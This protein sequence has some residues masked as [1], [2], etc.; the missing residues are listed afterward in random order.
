MDNT[1]WLCNLIVRAHERNVMKRLLHY[2]WLAF[3]GFFMYLTCLMI[4]Q[5]AAQNPFNRAPE[6]QVDISLY[7]D[8]SAVVAGESFQVAIVQDISAGWH[9]YFKNPGDSGAPTRVNW[10]L[11]SDFTAG[12]L[13][14]PVPERV[15]YQGL[16][17]FGYEDSVI[18]LT[19]ITPPDVL[20]QNSVTLTANLNWLAC[21]DICIPE[22]GTY[23]LTLPVH[24]VSYSDNDEIFSRARARQA[25]AVD[26]P[27][28]FSANDNTFTLTLT[29]GENIPAGNVTLF[30]YQDGL[31]K[32]AADQTVKRADESIT[33]T[34]PRGSADFSNIEQ[35]EFLVRV[36]TGTL[37]RAYRIKA[38]Y[39]NAPSPSQDAP[40][41]SS[42]TEERS[43]MLHILFAILGGVIL[44]LMPCV[45]PVLSLKALGL[46]QTRDKARAHVIAH[47]AAYLGGILISF[48]LFAG[49]ILGL[50]A[51]GT[52][53]GWGF[54]LQN[55]YN[56]LL[57]SYLIFAIGLNLSGVFTLSGKFMNLGSSLTQ[58]TT[59]S[60]SFFTGILAALVATPCTA[61][62]M[63]GAI[64][65]AMVEPVPQAF[66][67]FLAIGFGLA[68]PY[69][70]LTILPPVQKILPRPGQWMEHFRQ[71]LAFPMFLTA[72][73]LLWVLGHQSGI[74]AV[75]IALTGMVGFALFL[76]TLRFKHIVGRIITA[77]ILALILVTFVILPKENAPAAETDYTAYTPAT[78]QTALNS[79]DPVFINMTA[80]WC[81]TCKANENLALNTKSSRALFKQENVRILVGDWT[82]QNPDITEYL[83]RFGRNGVPLYV[84]YE[85]PGE[86]GIRPDPVVLPQ[87]LTNGIISRTIAP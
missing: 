11:P 19:T 81:I 52:S 26:W 21:N 77:I 68:L 69:V 1:A 25:K 45:F 75:F 76:W 8:T 58:K 78:L 85:A 43:L 53:L 63:A 28:E 72:A 62:F 46:I 35:A 20:P 41:A 59:Y 24:H 4:P 23:R 34:I 55:P 32:N 38:E 2:R 65:Y 87:I 3:F 49:I 37:P 70:L 73:W 36:D 12:N 27:A 33:V 86:N 18:F 10:E 6:K 47:G 64:G 56:I 51:F 39:N 16:V 79:D 14:F 82:N 48:A 83:A 67:I 17:N 71:F 54:Q 84:Y 29:P 9:T 60:S 15:P 74:D 66:L 30:P 44:N 40:L 80:A 5:A 22:Q 50:R 7:A 42:S 57:L 13:S 61:P 31:I